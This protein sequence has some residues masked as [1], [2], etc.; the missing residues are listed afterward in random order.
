MR[1]AYV[2]TTADAAGGTERTVLAQANWMAARAD[3]SV[4]SLYRTARRPHFAVDRRVT[5]RY[6]ARRGEDAA[7]RPSLLVP[8][9]WDDQ[10]DAA[11]DTAVEAAF[12]RL[13]ADVV[14]TTT[15]AIALLASRFLGPDT[16]IVHQEHRYS[17]ARGMG[18]EPLRACAHRL[19]TIAVLTERNAAWLREEL[20][21]DAPRIEVVPNGIDVSAFAQSARHQPLVVS[22]GRLVPGKQ[23]DHLV[24]A[25]AL[26]T[27]DHLEWRL[28]IYGE[29]PSKPRLL[30][31]ARR[32]G[33]ETRLELPGPVSDIENHLAKAS[34]F[35]L[36]SR[37]EA[38]SLVL[39]E[40]QAA[41]VPVVS[42]DTPVGPREIVA[43]TGG[44]IVVPVNSRAGL[45]AG[46]RTVIEDE[47]LRHRLGRLARDGAWQ[48]DA[49]TVMPTW[50][51]MFTELCRTARPARAAEPA[52]DEPLTHEPAPTPE[53]EDAAAPDAT[54]IRAALTAALDQHGIAW[55]PAT[56]RDGTWRISASHEGVPAVLAALR[57][58]PHTVQVGARRDNEPLTDPWPA[59]GEAPLLAPSATCLTLADALGR[60]LGSIELWMLRDGLRL[61]PAGGDGPS[62][63][64]ET[65]W[66]RWMEDATPTATGLPYWHATTFPIDVVYTWV[67]GADPQ[68]R[69]RR[70]PFL[71]D[72]DVDVSHDSAREERYVSRD[73]LY[74]SIRSVK[75]YLPWVRRIF[76]VTDRQV[77]RRV[78]AD[79]PDV[80]IV[81]HS[82]IF[83]DPAALPVFNSHAIEAS[84]H[85]IPGL[86]EHFIYFNDDVMVARPMTSDAFFHANGLAKF[87]PTGIPLQ[88]GGI[89]HAPHLAAAANNRE[90]V[91]A[92]FGMEITNSMLH[93]PHP[94][95]RSVLE[96]IEQRY[97]EQIRRTRQ[98]RFRSTADVS[99]L[100][101]LGQYFGF[102]RGLYVPGRIGYRYASL[103]SDALSSR[104]QHIL[105][106]QGVD[107]VA[108][109]EP[110]ASDRRHRD[111]HAI[112]EGFLEELVT[113]F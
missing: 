25:F 13:R 2:L 34:V 110:M 77:P 47:S 85:R 101:S 28:R 84:L 93:T 15:P 30:T 78:I 74:Y 113:R 81:D 36:T 108:I 24:R 7:L 69:A 11:T 75:R 50:L 70:A 95:R 27:E 67:D 76:V 90:I 29:G 3:V 91:A 9:A 61:R 57:V 89:E 71:A 21:A 10:F 82:E 99:L 105:D 56:D 96:E 19:D 12:R 107:V 4:L 41:G 6:A 48:F 104:L 22:A 31:E 8:R 5:V 53:P 35:A 52:P 72:G 103:R 64:D 20:G 55:R 51:A 94:H 38:Q 18:F 45:A 40:A 102:G 79:F 16:R 59:D 37:S 80:E 32:F 54:A 100:S 42:Y 17:P 62:A 23:F 112:L 14:V 43:A 58:L 33:M 39:L 109:A 63:V 46:I 68:W 87:F 1:V 86:S 66:L 65:V 83:P 26:A 60:P 73:E 44:G 88:H 111:E 106:D 97:P 49:G 92:E 98:A